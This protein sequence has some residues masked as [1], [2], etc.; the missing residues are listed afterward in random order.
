MENHVVESGILDK[1]R[2]GQVVPTVVS[3]Q[4][5]LFFLFRQLGKKISILPRLVLIVVCCCFLWGV[6]ETR[7]H[8]SGWVSASRGAIWRQREGWG[9]ST[10]HHDKSC[11][12]R[13]LKLRLKKGRGLFRYHPGTETRMLGERTRRGEEKGGEKE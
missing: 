7:I 9:R 12:L 8:M 6:S 10:S 1:K 4:L 3:E 13:E 2:V 11:V 5:F